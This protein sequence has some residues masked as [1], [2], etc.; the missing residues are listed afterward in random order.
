MAFPNGFIG[1]KDSI[2]EDLYFVESGKVHVFVEGLENDNHRIQILNTV[3]ILIKSLG[4]IFRYNV[5]YMW[6]EK[7]F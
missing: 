3:L 4:R 2:G 1:P 7:W 6:W 5:F